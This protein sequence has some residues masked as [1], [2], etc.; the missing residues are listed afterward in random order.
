MKPP[1]TAIALFAA[2]RI[3]QSADRDRSPRGKLKCGF[4]LKD[5]IAHHSASCCREVKWAKGKSYLRQFLESASISS[6]AAIVS[7]DWNPG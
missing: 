3:F 1:L 7:P 5:E 4:S 2:H 6:L